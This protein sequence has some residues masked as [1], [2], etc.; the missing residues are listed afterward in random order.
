MK[1][2]G[3]APIGGGELKSG[4]KVKRK[5]TG[6]LHNA[7]VSRKGRCFDKDQIVA[8]SWQLKERY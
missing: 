1:R 6:K 3:A 8:I 4:K 7:L 5:N 2:S